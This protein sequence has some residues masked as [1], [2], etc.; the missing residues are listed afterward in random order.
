MA[1]LGADKQ[2][3][4]CGMLGVTTFVVSQYN[5]RFQFPIKKIMFVV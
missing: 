5:R 2:N 4:R 3:V 1:E